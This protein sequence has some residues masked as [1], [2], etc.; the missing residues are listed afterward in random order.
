[1]KID[2]GRP[3]EISRSIPYTTRRAKLASWL[4]HGG[5]RGARGVPPAMASHPR[6]FF[7]R[8]DNDDEVRHRRRRPRRRGRCFAAV[9]LSAVPSTLWLG[10]AVTAREWS[11][12][13][14]GPTRYTHTIRSSRPG[15]TMGVV[16]SRSQRRSLVAQPWR[17]GAVSPDEP[18]PEP[19]GDSGDQSHRS[20]TPRRTSSWLARVSLYT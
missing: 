11:G 4:R 13:G 8:G 18:K 7:G 15:V 6:S 12:W 10:A 19:G 17:R 3:R 2:R 16:G 14:G 9:V 5:P 20:T 1:M